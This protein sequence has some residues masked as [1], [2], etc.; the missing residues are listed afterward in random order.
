[1][2]IA[3]AAVH[4][5]IVTVDVEKYSSDSRTDFDR[6][7]VRK[8]MYDAVSAAFRESDISW[9]RCQVA[10]VGDSLLV[11]L[12]SDVPKIRTVDRLPHRLAAMLR[13]HNRIHGPGAQLRLR[14]AVHAGEVHHDRTGIAGAS[15]IHACRLLDAPDLKA[16]LAA[17][18]A[19]LALIVSDSFYHDVVRHDPGLDPASFHRIHVSV[20][21]TETVA[22]LGIEARP[23]SPGQPQP[24]PARA[25]RPP[26]PKDPPLDELTR[27][28]AALEHVTP[29]S[30][31]DGRDQLMECL[32]PEIR[33]GVRRT[34]TARTD[35]ISIVTAC[36]RHPTGL[37]RLVEAVGLLHPMLAA[38]LAAEVADLDGSQGD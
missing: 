38:P 36:R 7:A 12:P 16:A 4:H 27:L 15:V 8:G 22:W 30:S 34:T 32:P 9:D 11:L 25:T 33:N 28:V 19:D 21:E 6:L 24:R 17:S 5:T 1:M 18:P 13:R 3:S 37:T 26:L 10:D 23:S 20:K 14:M 35:F 2:D 31:P 29:L